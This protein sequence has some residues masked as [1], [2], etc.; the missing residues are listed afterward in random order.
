[1]SAQHGVQNEFGINKCGAQILLEYTLTEKVQGNNRLSC[2]Y[3]VH[4]D[5]SIMR[6]KNQFVYNKRSVYPA[7]NALFCIKNRDPVS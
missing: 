3:L 1:M 5:Y 6:E 7:V 4:I 2:S